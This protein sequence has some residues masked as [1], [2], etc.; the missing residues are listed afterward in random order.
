MSSLL[1]QKRKR[2][3]SG[4]NSSG[5]GRVIDV[6][7]KLLSFSSTSSDSKEA[8]LIAA[9]SPLYK[10]KISYNNNV[11]HNSKNRS[12]STLKRSFS[13]AI[14]TD[15][16]NSMD[17]NAYLSQNHTT[18]ITPVKYSNKA[19]N[20]IDTNE[21]VMSPILTTNK[22]RRS[23]KKNIVHIDNNNDDHNAN[24]LSSEI[25]VSPNN[26]FLRSIHIENAIHRGRADSIPLSS[27]S[28]SK[29][30]LRHETADDNHMNILSSKNILKD[31][32]NDNNNLI[33]HGVVDASRGEGNV[34]FSFSIKN[35]IAGDHNIHNDNVGIDN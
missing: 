22:R 5:N 35:D 19:A 32:K 29:T 30:W 13:A 26:S 9:T 33:K 4:D 6:D 28:Y 18:I 2:D 34:M 21:M 1:L 20:D 10:R 11:L 12:S 15:V 14:E 8:T 24:K 7:S 17:K 31:N 27:S 23:I 3:Y 25:F 16:K